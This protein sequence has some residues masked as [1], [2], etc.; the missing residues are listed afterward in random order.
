[1]ILNNVFL[2]FTLVTKKTHYFF[3]S[4]LF[5]VRYA[6]F[7]TMYGCRI[8]HSDSPFMSVVHLFNTESPN[9]LLAMSQ[10]IGSEQ[11]PLPSQVLQL[12][13]SRYLYVHSYANNMIVKID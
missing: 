7:G 9:K 3:M 6:P 8:I 11:L 4:I 12:S 10:L 5:S 1:M 2:I 13:F